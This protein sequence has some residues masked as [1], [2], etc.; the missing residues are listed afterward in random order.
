MFEPLIIGMD[1]IIVEV[2]IEFLCELTDVINLFDEMILVLELIDLI[3]E[4]DYENHKDIDN[5]VFNL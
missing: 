5:I 1:F 4:Q 3:F 2:D